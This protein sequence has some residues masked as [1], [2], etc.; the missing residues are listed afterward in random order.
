MV[1]TQKGSKSF[2]EG[3][4]HSEET[5]KKM[6]EAR[7]GKLHPMYGLKHTSEAI[8]K[9]KKARAKQIWGEETNRKRS[10]TQKGRIFSPE[11]KEKM[12]QHALNR[13]SVK[14]NHPNFGKQS[15]EET[16]QKRSKA[17]KGRTFLDL[18]SPEK[19]YQIRQKIKEAR[20]K[21]VFPLTDTKIE[22]KIQDFL[23]KLSIK[24]QKHRNMVEMERSYQSDIFIP[25]MNLVLEC[26]GDYWHGS[27]ELCNQDYRNLNEKQRVQRIKDYLRTKELE[28]LG[29]KVLRLWENQIKKMNLNQ[30]QDEL[31]VVTIQ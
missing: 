24:Y 16:K 6:S 26:D 17:L 28:Y 10:E 30:F 7:K 22:V 8:D 11:S 27:L 19:A 12:R 5:K 29:F 25:S 4:N 18:H 15:S 1:K 14:E 31:K 20:S 13:F 2:F 9:I 3:R 21:Q 23:D